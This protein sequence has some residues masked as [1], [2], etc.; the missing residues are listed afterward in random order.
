MDVIHRRTGSEWPESIHGK[1]KVIGFCQVEKVTKLPRR[2]SNPGS[3]Q[4][5]NIYTHVPDLQN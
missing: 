4:T 1:E 5:L 2:E 3:Y